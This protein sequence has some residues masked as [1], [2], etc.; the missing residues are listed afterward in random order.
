MALRFFFTMSLGVAAIM[1]AGC[2][3]TK[4]AKPAYQTEHFSQN[5]PFQHTLEIGPLVACHLGQ[6]ALLSQGYQV[7]NATSDNVHG[8][9]YFQP[10]SN[11]QLQLDIKLVCMPSSNGSVIYVNAVQT[12]YELKTS[13]S[14]TGLSVAGIG[15]ISLPWAADKD[16]LIKVGEETIS[17]PDFYRRFFELLAKLSE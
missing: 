9:K 8:T 7:E 17:D 5:S 13:A 6:R 10:E 12:R 15:S 3:S 14:N 16:A 2:S 1:S 4:S 11:L